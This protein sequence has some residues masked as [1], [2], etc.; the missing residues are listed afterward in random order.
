[1]TNTALHSYRLAKEIQSTVGVKTFHVLSL[2]FETPQRQDAFPSVTSLGSLLAG[3]TFHR[4][5]WNSFNFNRYGS[6]SL[7]TIVSLQS[8]MISNATSC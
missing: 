1:M 7:N 3:F 4:V 2:G 5:T 8:A 6:N